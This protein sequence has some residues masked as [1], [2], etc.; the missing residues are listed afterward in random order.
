MEKRK[1]MRC[2]AE[3][4]ICGI[5]PAGAAYGLQ[6]TIDP[7]QFYCKNTEPKAAVCPVCGE[8]SV[9]IEDPESFFEG[10]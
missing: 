9:F 7:G 10:K 4:K 5:K 6:I 2:G 3:T 1:C 8:V